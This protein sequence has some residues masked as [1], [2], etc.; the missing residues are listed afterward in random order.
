MRAEIVSI[1][2]EILLSLP[3]TLAKAGMRAIHL[4]V[5]RGNAAARRV[6]EKL[7]FEPREDYMLMTR[8]L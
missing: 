5:D 8:K 7:R 2:T 6:Y 1:G 4:E 3:K